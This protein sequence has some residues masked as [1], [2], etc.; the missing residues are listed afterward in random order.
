MAPFRFGPVFLYESA[1]AARRWQTYAARAAYLF[2]LFTSLTVVQAVKL[3]G[4][5]DALRI[6]KLAEVG[7]SFFYAIVGTQLAL[8]LLAAPA[9]TAGAI[10]LDR[11]R[12]TLAHM[13]VTDLSATEIVLGKLGARL[14]PVL[15]LVIAGLPILALA[16]LLGGID[17]GALLGG[18]L[19]ALGVAIAGCS[20]ALALSVW[21]N[22]PH[23]VLLGTYVIWAIVLLAWP[24]WHLL[25]AR[26][27]VGPAPAWLE[28]SN[29]FWLTFAPYLRSGGVPF[30]H[31]LVFLALAWRCRRC[32]CCWRH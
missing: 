12:G 14:L 11:A 24:A 19:V 6:S 22:K 30:E 7:E 26:W 9:Y 31:Y 13:L 25:P 2:V 3:G 10:C 5:P 15:S 23:E 28:E 4:D 27:A 1:S 32:W 20:L 18:F 29:P 17:P 21:G 16:I 8:V